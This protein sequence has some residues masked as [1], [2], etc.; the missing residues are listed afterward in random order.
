MATS[1]TSPRGSS[2]PSLPRM[3]TATPASG[4]PQERARSVPRWDSSRRSPVA[5]GAVSVAPYTCT[6]SALGNASWVSRTTSVA[7]GEPPWATSRTLEVSRG[8]TR[9]SS[10]M[11]AS[12][13]GT[14]KVMLTRS[15][16]IRSRAAPGSN[17]GSMTC[18]PPVQ[19]VARMPFEPAAWKAGAISRY[20]SPAPIGARAIQWKVLAMRL[21][22]LSITPF[23]APV[24]PP[25]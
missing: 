3:R 7:I 1:P 16:S 15:R 20:T 6:S 14:P 12:M 25:V 23:E 17:V 9:C 8:R 24:V 10:A 2:W 5:S 22:W 13:V 11:A 21:R 4:W 19:S 18:R